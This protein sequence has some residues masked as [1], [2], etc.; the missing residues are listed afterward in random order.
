MLRLA[1]DVVLI[2][3]SSTVSDCSSKRP[4]YPTLVRDTIKGC[5]Y[6]QD[7]NNK[8]INVQVVCFTLI[9]NS[10]SMPRKKALFL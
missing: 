7:V 8:I 9:R 6:Q 2:W 10:E 4:K 3:D 1:D 5:D